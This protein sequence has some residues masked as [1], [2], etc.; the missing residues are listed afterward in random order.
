MEQ[1]SRMQGNVEGFKIMA[2]WI[3]KVW[4]EIDRGLCV[5]IKSEER[6]EGGRWG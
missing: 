6:K 4:F 3:N 2:G 5:T 1:I